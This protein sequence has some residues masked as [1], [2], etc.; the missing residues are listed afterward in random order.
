MKEGCF[1][2]SVVLLVVGGFVILSMPSLLVLPL[3]WSGY[4]KP[5][6]S[7]SPFLEAHQRAVK[8]F[9]ESEG[10]GFRR[11]HKPGLWNEAS[12]VFEGGSYTPYQVHLIGLT[13]EKG[14]RYF[15]SV[16]CVSF[17]DQWITQ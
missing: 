11:F 16:R 8:S 17:L 5:P 3:L 14:D 4:W 1:K 7:Q 2:A 12:V 15:E 9:V 6:Y 13:P 10:F